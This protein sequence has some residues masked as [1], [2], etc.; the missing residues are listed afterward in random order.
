[1]AILKSSPITFVDTTDQQKLSTYITSNLTTVQIKDSDAGTYNPDW[2]ST[3]LVL[4]PSV[5]LD[6]NVIELDNA[7]IMIE[8]KRRLGNDPE[9]ELVDGE[10]VNNGVLTV[11]AN[12]MRDDTTDIITYICRVTHTSPVSGNETTVVAQLPFTLIRTAS[13]AKTCSISGSQVF[14]YDKAG[15]IDGDST[16]VLSAIVQNVTVSEWQYYDSAQGDYVRISIGSTLSIAHDDPIW[17][18]NDTLKIKLVTNDPTVS[19]EFTILKLY[20][21]N[22]GN[23]GAPGEDGKDGKD[24]YTIFLSNEAHTFPG[25]VYYAV[26]SSIA[27]TRVNAYIGTAKQN[28][29][30]KAVDVPDG[31]EFVINGDAITFTIISDNF[32]ETSG[33]I[34]ITIVVGEAEFT[35]YFSW[36]V[37]RTGDSAQSASISATSQVFK[38]DTDGN[39][40]GDEDITLT[41]YVKN[42]TIKNWCYYGENGAEIVLDSGGASTLII[43]DTDSIFLSSGVAKIRLNTSDDDVYD[44]ITLAKIYDGVAGADGSAGK[45]GQDGSPGKDGEDAYTVLLTNES[46][47]FPGDVSCATRGATAT[48]EVMAFCGIEQQNVTITSVDAPDGIDYTITDNGQTSPSI[49]FHIAKANFEISSGTIPIVVQVGDVAFTKQFSWSVAYIGDNAKSMRI[50]ANSQVFKYDQDGILVTDEH[51]TLTA[52]PQ[53]VTI[54][55]WEY[56]DAAQGSFVFC[57]T[58]GSDTMVIGHDSGLFGGG[59]SLKIRV[60]SEYDNVYDVITITKLYD[61]IKGKDGAPGTPGAAAYTVILSNEAQ[62]VPTNAE[63]NPLDTYSYTCQIFV[64]KGSTELV[65]DLSADEGKYAI[66]SISSP[67]GINVEQNGNTITFSVTPDIAIAESGTIDLVIQLENQTNMI[68]KSITYA[69]SKAGNDTYALSIVA[70]SQIFKSTDG[71]TFFPTT[72]ALTPIVQ[73]LNLSD[74]MW[75]YGDTPITDTTINGLDPYIDNSTKILTIPC[76]WSELSNNAATTLRCENGGYS[77]TISIS[78]IVDGQSA[79]SVMLD[80]EAHVF[81]GGTMY[82]KKDSMADTCV[83]VYYGLEKITTVNVVSV[84]NSETPSDTRQPCG[85]YFTDFEYRVLGNGGPSPTI[86]FYVASETLIDSSGAIPIVVSA[87]GEYFYKMFSWSV[88][89]T[90]AGACSLSIASS[91]QVFKSSDGISFSPSTI[92]LTPNEQNLTLSS[93]QWSYSQDS[94]STWLD[95]DSDSSGATSPYVTSDHKVIV[96]N[97]CSTSSLVFRCSVTEGGNEYYDTT[98]ISWLSDGQSAAAAYT[99]VLSN[100]LQSIPA[101]S[102]GNAIDNATYSCQVQMYEGTTLLTPTTGTVGDGKFKVVLPSSPPSGIS[103]VA[104]NSAGVITFTVKKGDPIPAATSIDFT[105]QVESTTNILKKSIALVM[106]KAGKDGENAVTF[107]V[108]A[109]SNV[110]TSGVTELELTTTRYDGAIEIAESSASFQWAMYADG[111]WKTIPNAT[112]ASY[113][114]LSEDVTNIMSYKCTM[115]YKGNQYVDVVTLMDKTDIYTSELLTVGGTTFRNGRGGSAV[116]AI[117]RENGKEVDGFS[118]GHFPAT[119]DPAS[120]KE[121][122]YFYYVDH[123]DKCITPKIYQN[124]AWVETTAIPQALKYNWSLMDKTGNDIEFDKT[125]KVVYLSCDEIDSIGTI[126]CDI[127]KE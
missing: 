24:A 109:N 104:Q 118:G 40:V 72:I 54:Q 114:A 64:Y 113:T 3:N 74:C 5:L 81:P 76:K 60:T 22:D 53:N 31:M 111:D 73:H 63:C 36:S 105:I 57:G 44:I 121:G 79:Y 124:G 56:Y 94:G 4:T 32:A 25:N 21:G 51:I 112:G 28:V 13:N 123:T 78:K 89:Y 83:D 35:K 16:I 82:A 95:V 98:T 18:G 1:M 55:Q 9:S 66:S 110:F 59:T 61:G 8:W 47:V 68:T 41:A 43:A 127:T 101:D 17:G 90:G 52:Y 58:G 91:S 6:Q 108:N 97:G 69:A 106:A 96:P 116:F 80:N 117:V 42:V 84:G 103:S 92:T 27:E 15:N 65:C 11:T 120:G 12:Q 45:D 26:P 115:T 10:S 23:D 102:N 7:N 85:E 38:Y 119:S 122:D 62:T 87:N 107:V 48:T 93:C 86:Y 71:A 100:E 34:P 33:T 39:L 2:S 29:T 77:D 67:N 75:Y 30:I 126:Q 14:K 37:T 50:S 88:A 20:D 99:P 49:T 70:S 46:H 19:D 125:G